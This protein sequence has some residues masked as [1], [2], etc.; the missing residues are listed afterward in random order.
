MIFII[1]HVL[2][3]N[4][5]YP[6][7]FNKIIISSDILLVD[8]SL[9]LLKDSENNYFIGIT[10]TYSSEEKQSYSI[11]VV[12]K[13]I[14][15]TERY[16]P[17]SVL[18]NSKDTGK[19][20]ELYVESLDDYLKII[21]NYSN[22]QLLF[23][24]QSNSD[25]GIV[26][27]LFR[28]QAVDNDKEHNLYI[29]MNQSNFEE[30]E[31]PSFVK[32]ICNMQH[33]GI[34]TRLV[35]WTENKLLS[36]FFACVSKEN[37]ENDGAIFIV[38]NNKKIEVIDE[39]KAE[40]EDFLKYRFSND[41]TLPESVGRFLLTLMKNGKQYYFFKTRYYNDR[42]R[43]QKGLF[44]I[45]FEVLTDEADSILKNQL[46]EILKK[47]Q[48]ENSEILNININEIIK[49]IRAPLTDDLI[50]D[51]SSI[52]A[53]SSSDDITPYKYEELERQLYTLQV[54]NE[55][56]QDMNQ[57][58]QIENHLKLI[59]PSIY[60]KNFIIELENLG[61]NSSTVYPDLD[62]MIKYLNEKY[63]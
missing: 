57:I 9:I 61:I 32:K 2:E 13:I 43:I 58:T 53:T 35:D 34:P 56:A 60:K 19:S 38:I 62:G 10:S 51:I 37:E 16:N 52:I 25:W 63:T 1:N 27:S 12:S 14:E 47:F 55:F 54:I 46:R 17:E 11:K 40:F 49:K 23:R 29:E 6:G 48:E 33:L 8:N 42:I 39:T 3:Y 5:E 59:I 20:I 15:K 7:L 21:G 28:G 50:Q 4:C 24:G 26:S 45:Y 30:F 18:E 22:E 31:T 41:K 36:L 44:S